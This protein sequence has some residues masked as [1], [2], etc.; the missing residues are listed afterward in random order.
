MDTIVRGDTLVDFQV[1]P[2]GSRVRFNV[3]DENGDTG[4]LELPAA[5]LNQLLMTLPKVIKMALQRNQQDQS[6][7]LAY[8]MDGFRLELGEVGQDG[9]RR[10]LLTL[11]TD[12]SF[13][14]TFAITN[15]LLGVVAQTIIDQVVENEQAR[16][17]PVT[18]NS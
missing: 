12:G 5:C 8:P 16:L 10:Y 9:V 1:A 14:I 13:D 15:N 7:R 11:E 4:A 18:L 2:D 6:L 17:E 3:R